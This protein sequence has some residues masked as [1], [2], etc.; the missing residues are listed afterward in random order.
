MKEFVGKKVQ[1]IAEVI[2][3]ITGIV[4]RDR[5]DMVFVQGDKDKFP[6]RL[7]KS[8]IVAFKPLEAVGDDINLLVLACQ[9]PTIGCPG[10]KFVKEGDGFSQNDFKAFMGPCPAR[11]STCRTESFGEMRG[12]GGDVLADMMSGTM[13]GDYPEEKREKSDE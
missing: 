10:V 1:F 5:K 9:N 8:K 7:I 11:C 6:T 2:G 4:V 13:F 3:P 12:I